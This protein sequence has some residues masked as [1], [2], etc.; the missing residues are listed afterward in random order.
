V[1]SKGCLKFLETA[2][3]FEIY[4][5]VAYDNEKQ[6]IRYEQRLLPYNILHSGEVSFLNSSHMAFPAY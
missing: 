4:L 2:L 1:I 6:Q 5:P 3:S